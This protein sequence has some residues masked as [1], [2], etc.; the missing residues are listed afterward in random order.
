M[1][2]PGAT[3]RTAMPPGTTMH[4]AGWRRMALALAVVL[5]L[6]SRRHPSRLVEAGRRRHT[7]VRVRAGLRLGRQ[8]RRQRL[9]PRRSGN[10]LITRSTTAPRALHR[11]E[12]LRFVR[13]FLRDRRLNGDVSE[14]APDG[15]FDG[16]FASGLQNPLSLAFDNQGNLYVGQQTTPYIAEFSKTGQFV[17]NIG[18]L[19]TELSGDD[20][21]AL[22]L[23]NAPCTTRLKRPTFCAT[24]CAPTSSCRTSMRSHSRRST[25]R[26]ACRSRPSS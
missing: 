18:P 10:P 11:R 8:L 14:Y 12:R 7:S 24:T 19:A 1:T 5:L 6:G 22:L 2:T 13:Q 17:Q 25:R 21:I 4:G 16:V 3:R 15:T 26:R 20:W 9:Q 23:T